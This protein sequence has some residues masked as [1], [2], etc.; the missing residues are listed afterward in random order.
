M[1]KKKTNRKESFLDEAAQIKIYGG[2]TNSS[3][4]NIRL[5]ISKNCSSL[6]GDCKKICTYAGNKPLK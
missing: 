3:D 5:Y 1:E 4:S 6:W 2:I